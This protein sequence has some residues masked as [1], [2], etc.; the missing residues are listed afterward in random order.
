MNGGRKL[1][2]LNCALVA[3]VENGKL[4][5]RGRNKMKYNIG[6]KVI[7]INEIEYFNNP[8]HYKKALN[9]IHTVIKANNRLF[10]IYEEAFLSTPIAG[11][12]SYLYWR[13]DK[14]VSLLWRNSRMLHLKKDRDEIIEQ[15]NNLYSKAKNKEE[16]EIDEATRKCEYKIK[17]LKEQI[18][19]L[20]TEGRKFCGNYHLKFI[21]EKK[22]MLLKLI[23]LK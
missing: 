14:G 1:K 20:K 17:E 2:N 7:K 22:D 23:D 9:C 19:I 8:F 21:T 11:S 12:N 10:S 15:I 16:E 3:S 13:Q 5:K 4:I 6:D 18:I